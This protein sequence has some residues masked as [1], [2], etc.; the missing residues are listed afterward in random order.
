MTYLEQLSLESKYLIPNVMKPA[1][2]K[3]EMIDQHVRIQSV[4]GGNLLYIKEMNDSSII[5]MEKT[6]F[7]YVGV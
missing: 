7:L 6:S 4:R 5:Q 2:K 3:I 1:R